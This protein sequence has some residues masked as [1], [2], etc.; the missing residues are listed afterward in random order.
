MLKVGSSLRKYRDEGLKGLGAAK[1]MHCSQAQVSQ[2]GD[3]DP[4][5]PGCPPQK[6]RLIPKQLFFLSSHPTL[7]ILSPY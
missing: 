7:S 3:G 1:L 6:S 4:R 2:E 5:S